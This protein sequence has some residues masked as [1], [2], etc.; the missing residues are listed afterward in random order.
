[1]EA[2]IQSKKGTFMINRNLLVGSLMA[3]A[4]FAGLALSAYAT[5]DPKAL[6][7]HVANA[8]ALDATLSDK[9]E[10]MLRSDVGLAGSRLRVIAKSAVVTVGGSVPDEHALRRALDLASSV[11]GV[12]EVH[13]AMEVEPP[14]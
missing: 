14:K 4:T 3:A 1:M 13:N 12:R 7:G 10:T 2:G 9:V 11:R 6:P 5:D 8:E